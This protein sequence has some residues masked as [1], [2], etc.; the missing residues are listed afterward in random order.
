MNGHQH[1]DD[2]RA[3]MRKLTYDDFLLFPDDGQRHEL[4]DGEHYVTPSP[5]TRHQDLS[6]RL[7][8]ALGNH[9]AGGRLFHAP[10][11]CVFTDFDVVEP[12]LLWIADDQLGIITEKHV[13]GVPA[14]V[15]EILSPSTR[16]VD[17][18]IKRNLYDRVGVREYW[19]IDGVGNRIGVHR[20][21]AEGR[22]STS[23]D[24]YSATGD[25]LTTPLL[26]GFSLDLA[27]YFQ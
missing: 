14:L 15:V 6:V 20:R 7:I 12:D 26:T 1:T 25:L 19:V 8:L 24:L 2:A 9:L 22:L 27:N 10:Y 3:S 4:I 23:L 18:R 16:R 11:D 17:E 21:G 13:R 5:N